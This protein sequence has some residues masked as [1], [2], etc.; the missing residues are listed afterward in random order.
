MS[1]SPVQVIPVRSRSLAV[2]VLVVGIIAFLFAAGC[3]Y[4]LQNADGS[5]NSSFST[6]SGAGD[7]AS[8]GVGGATGGGT[9]GGSRS[10]TG[11]SAAANDELRKAYFTVDCTMTKVDDQDTNT[12]KISG[13]VP[14]S[15]LKKWDQRPWIDTVPL[16]QGGAKLDVYSEW[17]HVCTSG[18]C[19]P[20][21]FIYKGPVEIDDTITHQPQDNTYDWKVTILSDLS[22]GENTKLVQY[23]KNEEPACP[24]S[25]EDATT[26]LIT[27][28]QTCF[29]QENKP[30]TLG[31][32]VKIVWTST[33]PKVTLD[34]TAVFHFS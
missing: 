20:C 23:T 5:N 25:A 21:H 12:V 34:S 13:N 11:S 2:L 29:E 19:I 24:I 15:I 26:G 22:A 31:D 3:T 10:G 18:D 28:L 8:G 4:K 32:G 16:Y 33:D 6:N 7:S 9:G 30:F 17:N 1:L 27:E 14:L